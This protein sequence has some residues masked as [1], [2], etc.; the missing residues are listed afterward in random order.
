MKVDIFIVV[1]FILSYG[2]HIESDKVDLRYCNSD[3][4]IE[5]YRPSSGGVRVTETDTLVVIAKAQ[6]SSQFTLRYR[7]KGGAKTAR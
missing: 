7:V 3:T 5:Y 4:V 6:R 1:G 2:N